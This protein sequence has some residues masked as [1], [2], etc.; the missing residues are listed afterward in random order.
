MMRL[1]SPLRFRV[2]GSAGPDHDPGHVVEIVDAKAI[3]QPF[4]PLET[5]RPGT[6]ARPCSCQSY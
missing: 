5:A 6:V 3:L 2:A 4:L 1:E